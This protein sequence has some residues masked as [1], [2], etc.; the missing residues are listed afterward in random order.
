MYEVDLITTK[1]SKSSIRNSCKRRRRPRREQAQEA[2]PAAKEAP[3]GRPKVTCSRPPPGLVPSCSCA[4]IWGHRLLFYMDLR[5][6][7]SRPLHEDS[8]CVFLLSTLH[9]PRLARPA[10]PSEVIFPVPLPFAGFFARATCWPELF[11]CL[12][13]TKA[14]T[15]TG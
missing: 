2:T 1:D 7:S 5:P 8:F 11:N 6:S 15:R 12:T 9:L 13:A 14:Q 10:P 4:W 3:P